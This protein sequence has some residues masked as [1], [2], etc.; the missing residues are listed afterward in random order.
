M[1]SHAII[2]EC[3]SLVIRIVISGSVES[4]NSVSE[5]VVITRAQ[6]RLVS[7]Y[8]LAKGTVMMI[9]RTCRPEGESDI[10]CITVNLFPVRNS[11]DRL[12]NTKCA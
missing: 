12:T 4:G 3:S 8:L 6:K 7:K 2:E 9:L 5:L 1:S 11:H 10:R